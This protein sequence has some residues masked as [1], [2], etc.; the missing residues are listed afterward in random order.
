[1]RDI[2]Q[3]ALRYGI[4]SVPR[5]NDPSFVSALVFDPSRGAT[6]P[7]ARF[8]YLFPNSNSSIIQVRLR[9]DISDAQRRH[10]IGLIRAAV[11]MPSFRFSN[12]ERLTVTG[13]PVVVADL[14]SAITDEIIVLLIV[15]VLVMAA[16]LAYVF[17]TR[18]RLLPLA[19]AL[20]AAALTFGAMAIAG[21]SLTMASIAVLPVLI[22][23]SVD[24]AI[25]FQSRY[26]EQRRGGV[27][28][29]AAI[30]RA[31]A[32]GAPTIATAGI[33][34]AAGFLVLLLSPVPMVRSFG[35]LLVVGIVLAFACALSV[36]YAALA[37]AARPRA[38]QARAVTL[39]HTAGAR[40]RAFAERRVAPSLRGAGEL[41]ATA[42][43]RVLRRAPSGCW[44]S[45]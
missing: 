43:A 20:A 23:L 13:A 44:E 42:V 2:L 19:V 33:A 38:A 36:G 25:Q 45:R 29:Q 39:A 16:T 31:T 6:T 37:L 28:A 1:V 4:N 22:G 7:K 40:A 15:A 14:T 5:L 32:L 11:R 26:D 12:G 24:Y 17:R 35:V 27:G 34:T 10:A 41:L 8:A 3:L 18:M 21:A 9:P 30:A